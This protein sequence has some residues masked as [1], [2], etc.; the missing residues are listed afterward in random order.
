MKYVPYY[1]VSTKTQGDSGLGLK[2]QKESVLRFI[3]QDKIVQEFTEVESGRNTDRKELRNAIELCQETGAT[4]VIARLDRLSRNA[5]FT[6]ALRD[7]DIDFVAVDMPEANTLTIGILAV[8]AQ[9]EAERI[10][11]NTKNALGILKRE[12]KILGTP[13]NLTQAGRDKSVKVRK[14][15]AKENKNNRIAMTLIKAYRGMTLDF[16]AQKLNNGGFKTRNNCKFSPIQVS[17]L[18]QLYMD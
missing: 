16:I 6:M 12:G 15:K 9:A 2:D 10:S 3:G 8:V 14:Q 11:S 18:R 4:L 1:R 7:S 13:A 5:S 17:R